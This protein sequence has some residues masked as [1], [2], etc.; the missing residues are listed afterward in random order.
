M[1]N[2]T[3]MLLKSHGSGKGHQNWIES[4][5]VYCKAGRG[6]NG[7][8]TVGNKL[9]CFGQIHEHLYNETIIDLFGNVS[10]C[11]VV[12]LPTILYLTL[13]QMPVKYYKRYDFSILGGVGG[14]G[15][16]VIIECAVKSN[17]KNEDPFKSLNDVFK[18]VFNGD[19]KKQRLLAGVG[20]NARLQRI[21]G[22]AGAHTVLKVNTGL[23]TGRWELPIGRRL[24]YVHV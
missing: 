15:G 5:R 14:R 12:H 3:N 18:T 1:V 9:I 2:L 17:K 21:I 19:S 4:L 11:C 24:V 13:L 16:D 8:P 20:A 7:L 23:I 10:L 22:E 6:G